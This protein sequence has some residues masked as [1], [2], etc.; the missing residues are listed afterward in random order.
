MN[1]RDTILIADDAE[2]NRAVL[3]SIFEEDYKVLEA[4]NGEQA[5][6]L[7]RQ[8]SSRIAVVLLDLDLPVK[9]GFEVLKQQQTSE[10]LRELPVAVITGQDSMECGLRA[11]DLA[12]GVCELL[13]K[14]FE[15]ELVQRRVRRMAESNM[16]RENQESL[17]Q[18]QA[19]RLRESHSVMIA[20]LSSIIEYRSAETGQH[21][22][23][24]QMFTR[25]LLEDVAASCPELGLDK[26]K[27]AM[28]AGASALHDI[29]KIA[30]PDAILNKPGPLTVE[31]FEIMKT[32]T[33]MGCEMLEQLERIGD[34]EYLEF[35][36]D[37][38]RCHHERWDGG[39]YPAGLAGEDIPVCAQVVGVADCYDAL[40]TDR[41]YRKAIPPGQAFN[42]ILNGECG[43][44]GPKI[45]E[46]FKNVKAAFEALSRQYSDG[47]GERGRQR[48]ETPPGQGKKERTPDTLELSQMKYFTL[49]RQMDATV[50]EVDF[51]MGLYHL[52]YL[53]DR[54]FELLRSGSLLEES[55][56]NFAGNAVHPSDRAGVLDF[57]KEG[58]RGFFEKGSM[59]T[60]MSCRVKHSAT[61]RYRRCSIT[62]L[63]VDT[64]Y[65]GQQRVI[66][67][68]KAEPS[69]GRGGAA[70]PTAVQGLIG[71]ML[72]C[73]NDSNMTIV[74]VNDDFKRL[75]G[76]HPEQ[77]RLRFRNQYINMICPADRAEAMRQLGS[78]LKNGRQAE[79][80][81]RVAAENGTILWIL[82]KCCLSANGEGEELLTH[83]LIDVTQSR[84][85]Q[86]E[87]RLT[88]ERHRLIL[89]Q[90]NDVIFEWDIRKD[91]ISISSNW[92]KK[93]GFVP[94]KQD[95]SAHI[96]RA[97][98]LHPEDQAECVRLSR[99]L[100]ENAAYEER[101]I[102]IA[103]SSGR[104][105]W[106]RIRLAAQVDGMGKPFKVVGVLADIDDERGRS[107]YLKNQA[108][109]DVLT[110][111]YNRET[112][113]EK[114]E[115]YLR[116]R[117]ADETAAMF[118]VDVDDF[119]QVNDRYGHT[120]GDAVLQEISA[121]LRDQC[122]DSDIV[123]RI[124]GD[125]FL[126]FSPGVCG[127][128]AAAGRG[129]L[130]MEVFE[131]LCSQNIIK[132][133]FSCSIGISL[134]PSQGADFDLLY[135][136]GRQAL[137]LAKE[138]GKKSFCL[139]EEGDGLPSGIA[140]LASNTRIDS[141]ESPEG[142]EGE[143]AAGIFE[144]LCGSCGH[145]SACRGQALGQ[146]LELVGRRTG[147]SRASVARLST[148]GNQLTT[149]YEWCNE[150]IRS[151]KERQKA[152]PIRDENSAYWDHFNQEGL[153]YCPDVSAAAGEYCKRMAA[154]G[155]RSTLQC[156]LKTEGQIWGVL[157]V[158][159][160][161]GGRVWTREQV[162][163]V[164]LAA[165]MVSAF[166]SGL[167]V[168]AW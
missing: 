94:M 30:I 87:L 57:V 93:F 61:G 104:Y 130:M 140:G 13:L 147:V 74:Q 3:R 44:F 115:E 49:L 33:S 37:I 118:L 73:C 66:M 6:F 132:F 55:I 100:A 124:G 133:R 110:G 77:I 168:P 39:G 122:A 63:K 52:V 135:R 24:I 22:N 48:Q 43:V 56:R 150:G 60:S 88:L 45:L 29:G 68:W 58:M 53:A 38:C 99:R 14:P 69:R 108:E 153:F 32:H 23:R 127:R 72:Q 19:E 16:R 11:F 2:M 158:D 65:S 107:N 54:D 138:Q 101:E 91:S 78:Q 165:R 1:R 123:V 70:K 25:V 75:L 126:I 119:K 137:Y 26:G 160:C 159:D 152:V 113:R 125:E 62:A 134:C 117:G 51:K 114:V 141:D 144:I 47:A 31:E 15:P 105:R 18:E 136:K 89:E 155:A 35:A 42:M 5:L 120:F 84:Q 167:D 80:E 162:R 34:P 131:R 28:I 129:R 64:G 164:A 145:R 96:A 90:T 7:M 17:I 142:M 85:A 121:Q 146:V 41:V 82:D 97:S 92:E 149:V 157:G 154:S 12:P 156:L 148:D 163:A 98:H 83:L 81:Y 166:L 27:I 111:F 151:Q 46:S 9:D 116:G 143:L 8:Y 109:R 40:T 106:C 76:Y 4:E 71:G 59:R 20:A 102:R 36:R 67:V 161:F 139:Y 128:E 21:I 103:D 112:G 10:A 79:V 50:M 95:I 86:D